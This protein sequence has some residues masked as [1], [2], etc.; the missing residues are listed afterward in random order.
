VSKIEQNGKMSLRR[1]KLFI[2]EV[3]HLMKKKN[4]TYEDGTECSE[5]LTHKIQMLGNYPEESIKYQTDVRPCGRHCRMS[6]PTSRKSEGFCA[7]EN[8]RSKRD[9]SVMFACFSV[10]FITAWRL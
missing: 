8:D 4:T 10:T 5:M 7:R 9:T 2:K 3:K 1:P 6:S